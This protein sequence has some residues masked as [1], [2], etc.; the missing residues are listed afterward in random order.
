MQG[1]RGGYVKK[2]HDQTIV[3]NNNSR[4]DGDKEQ[5]E[6]GVKEEIM[7]LKSTKKAHH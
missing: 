5:G 2:M 4:G 6:E 3:A 1:G 7:L